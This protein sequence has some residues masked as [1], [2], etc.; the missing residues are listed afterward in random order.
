MPC[1]CHYDPPEES[2]K[3]IKELCSKLVEEVKYLEKI[4][5]PLGVSI[6]HA[7]ELIDHLYDPSKCKESTLKSNDDKGLCDGME[8]F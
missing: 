7:K 6:D 1:M 8:N 5:D 4:G 3:Y 2:K